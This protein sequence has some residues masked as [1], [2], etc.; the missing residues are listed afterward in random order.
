MSVTVPRLVTVLILA[1]VA[2]SAGARSGGERNDDAITPTDIVVRVDRALRVDDSNAHTWYAGLTHAEDWT[3]RLERSL[4]EI[5]GPAEIRNANRALERLEQL[6]RDMPT[7]RRLE[8]GTSTT[9]KVITE[10]LARQINS[11]RDRQKL[12]RALDTE[13]EA[14]LR[15]LEKLAAL[16]EIDE[17]LDGR[18]RE[19][20]SEGR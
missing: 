7:D 8:Q 6:A 18:D 19:S 16:R 10:L 2:L 4:L 11:N 13:R 9:L 1:G 14:H 5:L 12:S 17:E 15:T 20:E 3:A